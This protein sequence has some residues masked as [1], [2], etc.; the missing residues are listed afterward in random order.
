MQFVMLQTRSVSCQ[1]KEMMQISYPDGTIPIGL[2]IVYASAMWLRNFSSKKWREVIIHH[3]CNKSPN[4]LC[5]F[6]IV[7]VHHPRNFFLE[8]TF[9]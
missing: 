1:K 5:S 6:R 7:K 2:F 8:C 4:E 9:D 3:I